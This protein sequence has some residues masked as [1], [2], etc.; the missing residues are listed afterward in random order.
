MK[1]EHDMIKNHLKK[2]PVV[3]VE[4][5][6]KAWIETI[7]ERHNGNRTKSCKELDISICKIRAWIIDK[8]VKTTPSRIGHP[9]KKTLKMPKKIG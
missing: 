2:M 4:A 9:R 8:G 6:T 3:S 7:L 5:I 1:N